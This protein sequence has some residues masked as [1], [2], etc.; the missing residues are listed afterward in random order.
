[1]FVSI[2]SIGNEIISGKTVNTDASLIAKILDVNHFHVLR[3]LTVKDDKEEIIKALDILYLNANVVITTGGLGPTV[4]DMTK[5]ASS[6]YFNEQ[7]V[8]FP[9]VYEKINKYFKTSKR[10]M[11]ENNKSQAYFIRGSI[12]V[13]NNNGTAPGMVYETDGK[14]IIN[15]PGPPKELEPMLKQTVIPF[16]IG[17]K[18]SSGIKKEYR[19]MNIGESHA[20]TLIKPIIKKYPDI[21]IAPYASVGV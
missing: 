14:I 19:L 2:L 9:K 15:L 3:H 20:E 6:A 4:D 21:K 10:E 16:L 13:E 8:Y 12:I 18:N 5:E 11:P 17:K 1:M 7:L